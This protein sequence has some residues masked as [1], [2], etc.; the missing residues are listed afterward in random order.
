MQEDIK[1]LMFRNLGRMWFIEDINKDKIVY[2]IWI[3][4]EFFFF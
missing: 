3:K 1:Y 2:M 4:V